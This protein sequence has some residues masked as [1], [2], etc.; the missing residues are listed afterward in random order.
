MTLCAIFLIVLLFLY[1]LVKNFS[2]AL[3]LLA[4]L[5]FY[6]FMAGTTLLLVLILV[7]ISTYFIGIKIGSTENLKL[8]LV[9]LYIGIAINLIPLIV[10]KYSFFIID[11]FSQF[12]GALRLIEKVSVSTQLPYGLATIGV[13]GVSFYTFQA[14]SYLIDIYIELITPERHLGYFA[15]HLSFFPK[16]LQG[17]IERADKLIPQLKNRPSFDMDNIKQAVV[18]MLWGAFKKLVVADRL[19]LFVNEFYNNHNTYIGTISLIPIIFYSFQ[20]YCDFSGYTDFALGVAKLFGINLTNNFNSPYFSNSIADFWRRWHITLSKWLMDYLFKPISMSLR[21]NRLFSV[22]LAVFVTFLICGIWHGANWT[23]ILWGV[24]NGTYIILSNLT[25][26]LRTKILLALKVS[27]FKN[28]INFIN[29]IFTFILVS[30]TW[31]F[32]RAS[33]VTQAGEI[34]KNIFI[35]GASS[36]FAS[37]LTSSSYS[38]L[39]FKHSTYD[40]VL[41]LSSIVILLIIEILGQKGKHINTIFRLPLIIQWTILS[42]IIFIL[43]FFSVSTN[44]T[45]F[46]YFEF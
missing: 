44:E 8:K 40:L 23:F 36:S 42:L 1:Y 39:L 15:V 31:I 38:T 45:K 3:L 5:A 6:G 2:W 19:G 24:L 46:I 32:F 34:I 20:I 41:A 27:N 11:N 21:Y 35:P 43:I 29:I 22:N 7:I 25:K 12:L 9:L 4:G 37:L 30:F 17:P 33:S 26:G 13:I 28:V 16:I 14:I 18:L 10:L